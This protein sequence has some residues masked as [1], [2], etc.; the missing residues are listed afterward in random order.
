M[1]ADGIADAR[2]GAYIAGAL[3]YIEADIELLL[4]AIDRRAMSVTMTPE[5]AL[6]FWT[7]RCCYLNLVSRLKK[8]VEI[9]VSKGREA[10]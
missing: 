9:G 5:L 8:R 6:I 3:P 10:T 1:K 2:D 7:E 4:K